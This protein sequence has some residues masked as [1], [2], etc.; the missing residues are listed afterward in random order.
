MKTSHYTRLRR[1]EFKQ[2]FSSITEKMETFRVFWI[3]NRLDENKNLFCKSIVSSLHG[4]CPILIQCRVFQ[5]A[6]IQYSLYDDTIN[7]LFLDLCSKQ[8]RT[9]SPTTVR[10][11]HAIWERHSMFLKCFNSCFTEYPSGVKRSEVFADAY[12]FIL[13]FFLILVS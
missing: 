6:A 9:C 12:L 1:H 8:S 13:L 11:C 4:G 10:R 7:C 5:W 3:K 2:S